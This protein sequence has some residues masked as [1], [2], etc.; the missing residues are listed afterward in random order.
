[1]CG[2]PASVRGAAAVADDVVDLPRRVAELASRAGGTDWLMI[3]KYPPPASFLNFTS[4]K[5]GSMPVVSQSM[6]RPMVP[7]GAITV[8]WALRKPCFSPSSSMRSDSRRAAASRSGGQCCG[9]DADGEDREAF[10]LVTA[11]TL[12]AAR[13]WLRMTRSIALAVRRRSGRTARPRAAISAERRV[14]PGVHDRRERP[15]LGPAFGR[16]VRDALHHEQGAEVGVAEAERAEVERLLAR[17]AGS[18]TGPSRR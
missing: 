12:Y 9:V 1:M 3:L 7:V 2:H 8:T 16:V 6:T 18:G 10:V 11:A 5:S 4:A 15:A 14:R 17:R 13:R